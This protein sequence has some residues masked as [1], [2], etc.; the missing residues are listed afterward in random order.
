M[1][2]YERNERMSEIMTVASLLNDAGL[3]EYGRLTRAEM[4]DKLRAM[5]THQKEKA[6]RILC[7]SD[8]E[9]DVRI[10]RGKIVQ[11]LIKRL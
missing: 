9:F 3:M 11:H 8:D 7:A 5:A 2:F 1:E 6:E 4:I 10:V